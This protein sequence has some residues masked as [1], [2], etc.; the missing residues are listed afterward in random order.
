MEQYG[1]TQEEVSRTVGKSRPAIAN[2]LRLLNLPEEVLQMLEEGALSAGHART[3]LS[4]KRREDMLEAAK[5]AVEKE[6]SVRELERLA[7]RV[8]DEVGEPEPVRP[9]RKPRYFEEAELALHNHL[10]RRVAISGNQKKGMLQI[11]FYGEEDL[12][13]LM[14]LFDR[15]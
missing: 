4:F 11:E 5:L 10:G 3:L 14:K 7:K 2:A 12:T 13:E 8:N 1:L 6:L 15:D 9:R